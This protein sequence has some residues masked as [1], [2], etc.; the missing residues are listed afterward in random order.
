MG[1]LAA[2]DRE[3]VA[4]AL[5]ADKGNWVAYSILAF[6]RWMMLSSFLAIFVQGL[7]ISNLLMIQLIVHLENPPA[8]ES[9]KALLIYNMFTGQIR[10]CYVICVIGFVLTCISSLH[11][12]YIKTTSISVKVVIYW[13]A[14]IFWISVVVLAIWAV[15]QFFRLRRRTNKLS[16]EIATPLTRSN[17]IQ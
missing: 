9:N 14:W 17:D 6:E 13:G 2:V 7:A 3:E 16:I 11:L 12:F 4:S 5:E 10:T 15:V 1:V 8:G